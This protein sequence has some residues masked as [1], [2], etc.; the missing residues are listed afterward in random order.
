MVPLM[1]SIDRSVR[2]LTQELCELL[3]ADFCVT[4]CAHSSDN[5]KYFCW[6]KCNPILSKEIIEICLIN[7][8]L[9]VAVDRFKS[10]LDI[11]VLLSAKVFN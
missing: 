7:K 8:L 9:I 4:M 11:P 5:S 1:L 3:Q 10:I 2:C 6:N